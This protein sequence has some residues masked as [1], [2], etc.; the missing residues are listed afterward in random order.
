MA[1]V[2]KEVKSKRERILGTMLP[3]RIHKD[4]DNWVPPIISAEV[5]FF[6]PAKNPA[7]EVC[8]SAQWI[9]YKDGVVAGRITGIINHPF[10]EKWKKKEG[11]FG[12]I[13]FVDDKE[14]SDA[15]LDTVEQWAREKG[16]E[17]IV[18]PMGFTDFDEE[19][20]LIE[21][22]DEL[23]CFSMFYNPPYYHKHLESRGYA[24]DVD[25]VEFMVETP[26]EVPE[27]IRRVQ[28][29]V[30]KRNKLRLVEAKKTKELKPY[31]S[32]VFKVLQEAYKDLYGYVELTEKQVEYTTNT[33][34]SFLDPDF[35]KIVLDENDEVAAVGI[36]MPSLSRALQK[37]KGR[38]FPFG[39]FHI[40]KAMKKPEILD[41][42]LVAVKPEYQ[43]LGI[44][45]IVMNEITQSAINAGIKW[46]ETRAELEDNKDVQSFWKHF[47][48]RQHKRRRVYK[49]DL[50]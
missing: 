32:G 19:G 18:G 23:G 33:F 30:L 6:D 42:Y 26:E 38:L 13:D 35:T 1:V 4:N 3:F 15:L 22:F 7:Y 5:D 2:I 45:A 34:F 41:L 37:S 49:T 10:V 28:G 16:M 8:D 14:V 47:N 44:N 36:S 48:A 27:K 11:R 46:A 24:K 12:W 9:A 39:Y 17:S 29:L 43:K 50:A 31:V 40:L 25:W 21:G 20:M